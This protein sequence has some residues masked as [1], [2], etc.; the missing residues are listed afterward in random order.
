MADHERVPAAKSFAELLLD[1]SP[2]ALIA[3]TFDG[4]IRSWNRGARATFG[5][6]A[7]EAVGSRRISSVDS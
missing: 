3:L 2:D 4:R 6:T 1:E 5:Y 7:N